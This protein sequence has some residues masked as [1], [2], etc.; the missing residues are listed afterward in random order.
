MKDLAMMKRFLFLI[1]LALFFSTL[2]SFAFAAGP[3]KR[4][5]LEPL[6]GNEV[7]ANSLALKMDSA[8]LNAT[9]FNVAFT[10]T[11][12]SFKVIDLGNVTVQSPAGKII[13]AH[14]SLEN[15][16][17]TIHAASASTDA[18]VATTLLRINLNNPSCKNAIIV[19]AFQVAEINGGPSESALSGLDVIDRA[20]GG[21]IYFEPVQ[22][23]LETGT[24]GL[25]EYHA[26][27]GQKLIFIVTGGVS[28]Y[29]WEVTLTYPVPITTYQ[30]IN[31]SDDT[32]TMEIIPPDWT[33]YEVEYLVFKV[34]LVDAVENRT[35]TRL[36]F[37]TKT[38][39]DY[40]YENDYW[41]TGLL[42]HLIKRKYKV[43]YKS[44][45][46]YYLIFRQAKFTYHKPGRVYHRWI[47]VSNSTNLLKAS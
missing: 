30:Q 34:E 8:G 39:K 46:S 26:S 14:T 25:D 2:A 27:V 22:I 36:I 4:F 9:S 6:M 18:F 5:W 29:K 16:V 23:G 44:K 24:L 19:V 1:I 7:T 47:Q 21:V 45:T 10:L 12:E 37:K 35:S 31:T 42:G 13:S 3:A 32:A 28:P 11:S 33:K 17:I 43:Q 20:V 41:L 38:P 15:G 40:G